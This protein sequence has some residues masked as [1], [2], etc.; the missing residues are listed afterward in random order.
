[1]KGVGIDPRRLQKLVEQGS[2]RGKSMTKVIVAGAGGR[3]GGRLVSLVKESKMLQLTGALEKKGHAA[4]GHDAGEV[5]GCGKLGIPIG[6]DLTLLA[7]RADVLIEF[8]SPEATLDHLGVMASKKKAMV[9]G[10]TGLSAEQIAELKAKAKTIPC[11]FAPNMSVGVNVMLKMIAEMARSLGQDYD[12][13]VTEAHH[14]LKKDA[15]SGTALKIGQ[16]LAEATG[17]DL[18]KVA[19]YG[20]KGMIGERTRNEIGIQVIRA[21]DIVGDH[22]VLFGGM[23]ERL[24]VTHRASNRDTFANGALRAAEWVVKQPPGLYDM[25]DVL[26][27][28]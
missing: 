18:E 22:T 10:T 7:D 1:M 11:V 24:E 21:G 17:R 28:K 19:I 4:V 8:T 25:Q 5:A 9:I 23:G 12:I 3:M 26:G 20:R 2:P 16:V 15:P 6:D 27:L 13:E 14:R